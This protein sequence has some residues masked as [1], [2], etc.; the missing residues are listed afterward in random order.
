MSRESGAVAAD[1]PY[2][3]ASELIAQETARRTV[4][5]EWV[6]PAF[7]PTAKFMAGIIY[8]IDIGAL[9]PVTAV[10]EL[11]Y[12]VLIIHGVHDERVPV[13]HG[14]RVA[15]RRLHRHDLVAN[16]CPGAH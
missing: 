8:G 4:F 3:A 12:P 1:S 7:V 2:A 11:D 10:T 13:D 16:G 6:T 14:E 5:P 9:A 15:G